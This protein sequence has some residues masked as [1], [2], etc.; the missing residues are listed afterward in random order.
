MSHETNKKIERS[1]LISAVGALATYLL[2]ML[3]LIDVEALTPALVAF[4]T[5]LLNALRLYL[6]SLAKRAGRTPEEKNNQPQ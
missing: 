1:F 2:A 6:T 4:V 3:N 5:W